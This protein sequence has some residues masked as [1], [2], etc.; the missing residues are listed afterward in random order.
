MILK[1]EFALPESCTSYQQC[2]CYLIVWNII[3]FCLFVCLFVFFTTRGIKILMFDHLG[4]AGE[5]CVLIFVA[6]IQMCIYC[7]ETNP[8]G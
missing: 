8:D 4:N 2:G 6:L 5:D 7:A 3:F 1:G